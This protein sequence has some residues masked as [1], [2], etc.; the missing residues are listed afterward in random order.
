MA[1]NWVLSP[2]SAKAISPKEA[3]SAAKLKLNKTF[4]RY[5][6]VAD[7]IFVNLFI[8]PSAKSTNFKAEA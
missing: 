7:V 6:E 3:K 8:Y 5:P 1:K 2:I 4:H